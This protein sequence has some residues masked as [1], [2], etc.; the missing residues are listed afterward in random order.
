MV[1]GGGHGKR[2]PAIDST[3]SLQ[4]LDAKSWTMMT[5]LPSP[6]KLPGMVTLGNKLY[7]A[8]YTQHRVLDDYYKYDRWRRWD[9]NINA[10]TTNM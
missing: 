3:E 7:V 9:K 8:G 6:M 10:K 1:V 5:P 4:G 2:G